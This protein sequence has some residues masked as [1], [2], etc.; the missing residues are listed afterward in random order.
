MSTCVDKAL[1]IP[2]VP[3]V[4]YKKETLI[5]IYFNFCF[6]YKKEFIDCTPHSE[7]DKQ[8]GPLIMYFH[9]KYQNQS[10]NSV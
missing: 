8:C 10:S 3:H 7:K 1:Y 4:K 2:Q 9:Y 5:Y 6:K